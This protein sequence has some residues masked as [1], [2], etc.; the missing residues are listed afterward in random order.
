MALSEDIN[1]WLTSTNKADYMTYLTNN[2]DWFDWEASHAYSDELYPSDLVVNTNDDSFKNVG[3]TGNSLKF[4]AVDFPA[5][6]TLYA[7]MYISTNPALVP[8]DY[9]FDVKIIPV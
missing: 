4:P 6:R 8:G 2:I 1:Y 9:T 7:I 3:Y 5:D